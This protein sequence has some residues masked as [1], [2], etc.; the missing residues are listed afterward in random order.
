MELSLKNEVWF[1]N[2]PQEKTGLD[3]KTERISSYPGLHI[4]KYSLPVPKFLFFHFRSL[5]KKINLLFLSRKLRKIVSQFDICIDFG[6]YM[7][8]DNTN[9]VNANLKIYFPV[10]DFE[11][12]KPSMRG[13]TLAF[14]V[15]ANIIE[16]FKKN[17]LKCHFINHGLNSI[18][19]EH[20]KQ[21]LCDI[22]QWVRK[23][24]LH[25]A[26]AGNLFIPFIDVN[27]LEKVIRQNPD[28]VFH[29]FG[30]TI[31]N[32]EVS[33]HVRWYKFLSE[34][35]NVKLYGSIS[36]S[37]L[38]EAFANKDAFLLCYK[39]DNKNYHAENSHKIFE[40]F[41]TGKVIISTPITLYVENE[42]FCM[43][44][45]N[46]NF[47]NTFSRGI[48]GIE[49]YN[50][51]EYLKKRILFS[52]ENEYSNQVKKMEKIINQKED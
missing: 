42:L 44:N 32:P 4:I 5:Y 21:Q 27:A 10:D 49:K 23:D 41:S 29:F 26:Y 47:E 6:N 43:S 45:G 13:S 3:F 25:I 30:S 28:I 11:D 33:W 15:S 36:S 1:L 19:A 24:V 16:K 50:S 8:Y 52:L 2:A 48:A 35:K 31:H 39:P 18:F 46:E 22:K 40:Y 34:T 20:A 12:L 7:L 38:A 51:I 14:S 9:F 17:G 37:E